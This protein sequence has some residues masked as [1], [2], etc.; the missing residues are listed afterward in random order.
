MIMRADQL[1]I[2]RALVLVIDVQEKL[3]P[4]IR[5]HERIMSASRKLLDGIRIFNLPVV[6]TEQYPKGLGSTVK[7]IARSLEAAGAT[8]LEKPTFSAWA[9]PPLRDVLIWTWLPWCC[10]RWVNTWTRE[11]L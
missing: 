8:I 11:L 2:T 4:H 1:D 9:H 7:P 6:A 10:R 5:H 3:V